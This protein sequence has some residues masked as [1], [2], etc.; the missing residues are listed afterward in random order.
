[1]TKMVTTLET[2]KLYLFNVWKNYGLPHY[3]ISDQGPQFASQVMKDLKLGSPAVSLI[4]HSR[5]SR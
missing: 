4:I 5:K 1:M 2:A 3:I